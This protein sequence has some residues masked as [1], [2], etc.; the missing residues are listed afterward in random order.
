MAGGSF[1]AGFGDIGMESN[2]STRTMW[3]DSRM[4]DM[5]GDRDWFFDLK[6]KTR[7]KVIDLQPNKPLGDTTLSTDVTVRAIVPIEVYTIMTKPKPNF[8]EGTPFSKHAFGAV[9]NPEGT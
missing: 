2:W 7:W 4:G 3:F 9:R 6:E 5:I 8:P 1:A